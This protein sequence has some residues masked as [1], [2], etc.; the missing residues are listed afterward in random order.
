MS[1][2]WVQEAFPASDSLII[3]LMNQPAVQRNNH[4]ELQFFVLANAIFCA[5]TKAEI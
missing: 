4:A 1:K 3:G 5:R 2:T